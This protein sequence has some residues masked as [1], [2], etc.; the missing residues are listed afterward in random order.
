MASTTKKKLETCRVLA[1]RVVEAG[2]GGGLTLVDVVLAEDAGEALGAVAGDGGG[3]RKVP[4]SSS[5]LAP[6]VDG[7]VVDRILA[8]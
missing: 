2:G 8:G 3:F 6:V 1:D 7:A 5:V 4:A